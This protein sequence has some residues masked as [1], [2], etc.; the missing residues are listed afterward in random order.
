MR[1]IKIILTGLLL[2]GLL[3]FGA[4]ACS[5]KEGEFT[6]S[7]MPEKI[8]AEYLSMCTL[9]AVSAVDEN[10]AEYA[11]S[12]SVK[13]A[14]G[15]NV[16]LSGRSFFVEQESDY[17]AT[18]IVKNEK[19]YAKKTI[20]VEVVPYSGATVRVAGETNVIT[21]P[22]EFDISTLNVT[23]EDLAGETISP[24]EVNYNL[25]DSD[26]NTVVLN[27]FVANLPIGK[28]NLEFIIDGQK[29]FNS[30]VIYSMPNKTNG[31]GLYVYSDFSHPVYFDMFG[32]SYAN[33]SSGGMIEK[34]WEEEVENWS[35]T[36]LTDGWADFTYGGKVYLDSVLMNIGYGYEIWYRMPDGE[37]QILGDYAT[38][39]WYETKTVSFEIPAGGT[40]VGSS[41]EFVLKD[42]TAFNLGH[43]FTN[44]RVETYLPSAETNEKKSIVVSPGE[45]DVNAYDY[46]FV[47]NGDN[48]E[49]DGYSIKLTKADNSAVLLTDGKANL[50]E[51]I[52]RLHFMKDGTAVCHPLP[53]CVL[54]PKQ[55]DASGKYNYLDFTADWQFDMIMASTPNVASAGDKYGFIKHWEATI[56]SWTYS[57]ITDGWADF[58]N[59]G[60]VYFDTTLLNTNPGYEVWL[61]VADGTRTQLGEYTDN[62]YYVRRTFSFEIPAGGT[63][64]GTKIEIVLKNG[65]TGYG[66]GFDNVLIEE[67]R[68]FAVVD[69]KIST[70][71]EPGII[72]IDELKTQLAFVDENGNIANLTDYEVKFTDYDGNIV[73]VTDGKATVAEGAYKLN[74]EKNGSPAAESFKIYALKNKVTDAGGKYVYADFYSP[75]HY[76]MVSTSFKETAEAEWG[77]ALRKAYT[78]SVESWSFTFLTDG[79]ADFSK[80]GVVYLDSTIMNV[81]YGYEAYWIPA[82][83]ERVQIADFDTTGDYE[84]KTLS[85][86]LEENGTLVGGKVEFV[87]KNKNTM[88]LGHMV[89]N[90]RIEE[91]D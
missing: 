82:S 24:A 57:F 12:V 35:A 38:S 29:T 43:N 13:N 58:T 20:A 64:T 4:M 69:G 49:I 27:G 40:L 16:V 33:I 80:G 76:D 61:T 63:I 42:K 37:K 39:G 28:Y 10:G 91:K 70:V 41:I 51:G 52:Y 14:A 68:P 56:N 44:V 36:F 79:L 23:F 78:E 9:P 45:F 53:V 3:G 32:L 72:D 48:F 73:P 47:F 1:K 34:S 5:L 71:V 46:E 89:E 77:G 81:G 75:V 66:F 22:G 60:K 90:I 83:G 84:R 30:A 87:L 7:A 25:L 54:P 18:Y 17:T 55:T 11:A 6:W 21:E 8:Q 67:N 59:G 19:I 85:F 65:L 62:G 15:E 50:T 31:E 88:S 74:I 2:V 86:E 26:G